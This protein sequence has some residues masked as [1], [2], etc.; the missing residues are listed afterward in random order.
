MIRAYDVAADGRRLVNRRTLITAEDD[1]TRDRVPRVDID[2][3]LWGDWGKGSAELDAVVVF[4]PK[5]KR[6]GRIA[7]PERCGNLCFGGRHRNR[8]FLCGSASLYSLYV[9]TQGAPGL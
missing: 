8:L 5:G 3:N 4:N 7:L 9:N 6:V 1:G 2:G